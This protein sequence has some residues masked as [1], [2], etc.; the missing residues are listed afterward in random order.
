[1]QKNN[2]E[3]IAFYNS[4]LTNIISTFLNMVLQLYLVYKGER[5][6]ESTQGLCTCSIPPSHCSIQDNN[7][8]T[9]Q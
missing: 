3:R 8:V 2:I 9:K 7:K 4:N 6:L 1:M 5:H